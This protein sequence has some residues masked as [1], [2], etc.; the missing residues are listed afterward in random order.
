MGSGGGGAG[1]GGGGGGA[2]SAP[3]GMARDNFHNARDGGKYDTSRHP[4]GQLVNIDGKVY[5]VTGAHK[6]N[7]PLMRP[8]W[9]HDVKPAT[10]TD[11]R[12]NMR[13]PSQRAILDKILDKLD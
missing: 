9:S 1:R 4:T 7:S 12:R 3:R 11:V 13:A 8:G 10:R 6:Y 2:V 5:T